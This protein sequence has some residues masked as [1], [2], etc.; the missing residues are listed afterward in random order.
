MLDA[1]KPVI[2]QSSVLIEMTNLRKED[3]GLTFMRNVI[4]VCHVNCHLGE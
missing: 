2:T 3:E 4:G 1:A